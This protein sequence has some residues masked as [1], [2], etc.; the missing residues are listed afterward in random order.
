MLAVP[1]IKYTVYRQFPHM[2]LLHRGYQIRNHTGRIR[3]SGGTCGPWSLWI[4]FAYALNFRGCRRA[5]DD[6][7]DYACFK[8][9]DALQFWKSFAV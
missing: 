5:E 9:A 4:C 3:Q 7:I 1:R 2:D 8:Q 6:R